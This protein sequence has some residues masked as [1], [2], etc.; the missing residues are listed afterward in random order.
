MGKFI[1]FKTIAGQKVV[2]NTD[3]I[4]LVGDSGQNH[5]RIVVGVGG[6]TSNSMPLDV[7]GSYDEIIKEITK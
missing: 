5:T 7:N 1:E 3:Y 2:V 6:K 4:V